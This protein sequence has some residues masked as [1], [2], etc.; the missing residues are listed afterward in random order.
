MKKNLFPT[1]SGITLLA[2]LGS[3]PMIASAQTADRSAPVP[4]LQLNITTGG[5]DLREGSVAYAEIRL[6]DGRTLP[7]TNLNG[8]RGLGGNSRN[9]FSVSLPSGI[10][11]GDLDGS[12]LTISHDGAPRR[13]PDGYD[14][15]NVDAMS[16]TTARVCSGGLSVASATGSPWVRFTGG[17]TFEAVPFRAPDTSREA[18]PSSL[19]L[20]IVTGGDDLREGS[21]AYAEIR[22]R[23]G[24]TLPRVNLTGGRG[25][26]GNSVRNFSVSLPA[27]TRL[28]DLATLTLSHDGAPR[29]PFDGYDNW[30]VDSLNVTTP[31]VCSSV[32]LAN[33][34]GRP[35]V[36]FTGSKTFETVTLRVR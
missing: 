24:R 15:W 16:V 10:Q 6:R 33:L 8:G 14:N 35:W 23:D 25:L 7:K 30:N 19:G 20:K 29:R 2:L 21:V 27:G 5:D 36:R 3:L 26:T 13:F 9:S 28:G 11:L 22:L 32:S 18:S 1:L 17:K 12:L 34:S 4:T 31:E